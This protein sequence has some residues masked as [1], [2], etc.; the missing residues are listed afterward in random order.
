MSSP[1]NHKKA[2]FL[3][4]IAFFNL[5]ISLLA[6]PSPEN[7]LTMV[8]ADA[9]FCVRINRFDR[10]TAQADRFADQLRPAGLSITIIT[11][12][13]LMQ[14]VGDPTLKNLRLDGDIAVF[15]MPAEDAS[16]LAVAV[17]LPVTDY[18]A[19]LRDHP[20]ATQPDQHGISRL[21]QSIGQAQTLS[22]RAGQYAALT[23][24]RNYDGMVRLSNSI[25]D[26]RIQTLDQILDRGRT[27]AAEGAP[28]WI[29]GNIQRVT[30]LY[31][32]AIMQRLETAKANRLSSEHADE[33]TR[34]AAEMWLWAFRQFFSEVDSISWSVTPTEELTRI[35]M[36]LKPLEGTGLDR[37]LRQSSPPT[38]PNP[39]LP[40]LSDG[41]LANVAMKIDKPLWRLLYGEMFGFL[42]RTAGERIDRP[43]L[44]RF[45]TLSN[46]AIDAFGDNMVFSTAAGPQNQPPL[47]MKCVFQIADRQAWNHFL[48]EQVRLLEE[49]AVSDIYRQLGIELQATARRNAATH[50]GVQIDSATVTLRSAQGETRADKVLT[51]LYGET[52]EYRWALVN[53]MAVYAVGGDA[54]REI[55]DLIDHVRAR[56]EQLS[57]EVRG[58][59]S[60][61]RNSENADVIGT[62]NL[63][64]LIQT[65][66]A[67]IRRQAAEETA[68]AAQI[69]SQSNLAFA[70][71]IRDG[72]VIA[73]SVLPKQHLLE[74]R[75][76]A[77]RLRIRIQERQRRQERQTPESAAVV[78]Q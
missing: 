52:I 1:V 61:L 70:A 66:M 72:R 10:T 64:R 38:G 78:S 51:G 22:I 6:Q 23:D 35:S 62:C 47:R 15:G 26:K 46:Q 11:R 68:P 12:L 19:F 45:K 30:T 58:A 44:Q 14:M 34:R 28:V 67:A 21:T 32:P 13:P 37:A 77:E 48:D 5:A 27:R 25:R 74:L 56:P 57:D 33:S 41:N 50:N 39:L 43:Q 24:A 69:E 55:R 76:I 8:P 31:G 75:E 65:G 49:G 17:L 18:D 71:R 9:L 2:V 40:H 16:R 73:Q 3:L 29:Y 53:N 42:E 7:P 36:N 54:D 60:H 59:I 4:V 63:V 20:S